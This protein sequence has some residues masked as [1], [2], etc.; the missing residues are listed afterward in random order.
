MGRDSIWTPQVPL[1]LSIGDE[2]VLADGSWFNSLLATGHELTVVRPP[3]DQ[4]AAPKDTCTPSSFAS[5]PG[6]PLV[7]PAARRRRGRDVG[8]LRD[9]ASRRQYEPRDLAAPNR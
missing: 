4:L 9:R 8:L 7:L 6:A 1:D 2:L 3:V 5:D